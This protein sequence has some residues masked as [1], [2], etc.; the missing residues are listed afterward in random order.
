MSTETYPHYCSSE[1]VVVNSHCMNY[2]HTSFYTSDSE[3]PDH[4]VDCYITLGSPDE[5]HEHYLMINDDQLL[6]IASELSDWCVPDSEE[7][8]SINN[9]LRLLGRRAKEES[10]RRTRKTV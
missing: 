2:L 6:K 10:R 5:V 3:N 7:H 8:D 1:D 9:A 4:H